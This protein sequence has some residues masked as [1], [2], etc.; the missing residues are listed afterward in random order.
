MKTLAFRA[1]EKGLELVAD[2]DCEVPNLLTGDGAKL[3][4]ILLN[5]VG[6]SVKFTER[7]E[8]VVR[9]SLSRTGE[10]KVVLGFSVTDTGI[11]VP[12]D[13]QQEIFGA[14]AQANT[15][16]R[17]QGT[18]LGLAICSR[19]V[20]MM[21]GE[22]GVESDVGK[23][24]CFRF[25]A[26]FAQNQAH[27]PVDQ[28]PPFEGLHAIVVDD[29][30][31]SRRIL[32]KMLGG[33]GMHAHS[34]A[35]ALSALAMLS[36]PGEGYDLI[37]VDKSMPGPDGFAF[38]ERAIERKP[39]L[40]E[41][42]VMMLTSVHQTDDA[43]RCVDL[44][45]A[46]YVA[47]PIRREELRGVIGELVGREVVPQVAALSERSRAARSLKVLVAEDNS[48]NQK[49]LTRL[50]ELEGHE[51][52]LAKTGAQA[53]SVM[54]R[55]PF[56]LVLMDIQMP[57][58]DGFS[59]VASRRHS[60][61]QQGIERLP[62]VAVTAYATSADRERCLRAGFDYFLSKP[63]K[64]EEL[65]RILATVEGMRKGRQEREL[66]VATSMA[67]ASVESVPGI[68]HV[69]EAL[70]RSGGDAALLKELAELF[71]GEISGWMGE[72]SKGIET[73]DG[74][75]LERSAHTIKG[76]V[77][78]YGASRAYELSLQLERAGREGDFSK[79]QGLASELGEQVEKLERA[80]ERLVGTIESSR[81]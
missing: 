75:L 63:L 33:W 3:R 47:K 37:L 36:K 72:L 60:E 4:Q 23:G 17:R 55:L 11:G 38:V 32:V 9:V 31:S 48:V 43:S 56:D 14:F 45:L 46:G 76:A 2:V 44:H 77:G 69:G 71:L 64:V 78:H 21:G 80:L 67:V 53:L 27:P 70:K 10:G 52:F 39:Q 61:K 16:E 41:K 62:I 28:S 30:D 79:A 66:S 34:A 26:Q 1:H 13:K 81:K 19:L 51:V 42:V 65:T 15:G 73:G 58:V 7:G 12:V 25:T 54:E 24:S 22:I 29:N 5:L 18:G 49:L 74:G 50:L 35:D 8:V 6:N 68:L 59:A 20:S 40:R 57:Q